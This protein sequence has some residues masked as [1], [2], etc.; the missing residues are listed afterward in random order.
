MTKLQSAQTRIDFGERVCHLN[1][2]P[3]GF[4]HSS[5]SSDVTA[6]SEEK[7]RSL[8]EGELQT[9]ADAYEESIAQILVG[10]SSGGGAADVLGVGYDVNSSTRL[11]QVTLNRRE[12][13]PVGFRIVGSPLKRVAIF[14]FNVGESSENLVGAS[15][16][17]KVMRSNFGPSG[18]SVTSVG[19][20]S[21]DFGLSNIDAMVGQFGPSRQA[22]LS[23]DLLSW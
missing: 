6:N 12:L 10:P 21:T 7:L 3:V 14:V 19:G 8:G 2:D 17:A 23:R 9:L 5:G 1:I 16:L 22:G 18:R 15:R 11:K 4:V 20:T 13:L